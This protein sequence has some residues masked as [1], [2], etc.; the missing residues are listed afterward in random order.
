MR[1]A[2]LVGHLDYLGLALTL[3][4]SPP[5]SGEGALLLKL[6]RA[7]ALGRFS[8]CLEFYEVERERTGAPSPAVDAVIG[9]LGGERLM[10]KLRAEPEAARRYPSAV[11]RLGALVEQEP[12]ERLE[13]ALDRF[14]ERVALSK[15]QG[16]EV[17]PRRVN[18]L[19][20][21]STKGLEFS[22]VYV[23]GVEDEQLPGWMRSDDDPEIQVQEARRLLYVGMTRA[24]DRVVLT[25][26]DRRA[27]KP[28]GGSR[29]LEEMDLT[30]ERVVTT[31]ELAEPVEAGLGDASQK[32]I[33][34]E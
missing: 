9:R 14:L 6:S 7:N 13:G 8:D 20:L 24:K 5:R 29:F 2:A 18:L 1:K 22:R 4:A 28:G 30:P 12:G 21:H 31:P 32:E 10:A 26:A 17:D 3:E 19:T 33:E 34:F 23:V 16:A 15:S 27:G 25:R 11:A